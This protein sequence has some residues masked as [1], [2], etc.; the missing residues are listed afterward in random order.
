VE[1]GDAHIDL[2]RLQGVSAGEKARD[3]L[4]DVLVADK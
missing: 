3:S 2:G 1:E 4:K